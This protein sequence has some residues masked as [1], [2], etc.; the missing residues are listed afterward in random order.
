M[1]KTEVGARMSE[2][3]ADIRDLSLRYGTFVALDRLSMVLPA[4][5]ITALIGESGSGK[6]SLARA[7]TG[8]L[9]GDASISGEIAWPKLA[10]PPRP[11][12]D[13]GYV[14]QEPAASFDPVMSIG[15]QL[16]E[17]LHVTRCLRHKEALIQ[18]QILLE[19]VRIP[20]L[21]EALKKYPHQFSGGQLQRIA[22]AFALAGQ[23]RLL[24]ADEPTSALDT[25]VQKDIVTLLRRLV[26][27]QHLSL[28][29]ITHD[30]ALA[31]QIA[32][33]IAVL[34]RGKLVDMANTD[35]LL[36]QPQSAYTRELLAAVPRLETGH[37]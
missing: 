11:G 3:L 35:N 15:A 12:R 4:Q 32:D 19:N 1:A 21:E 17:I 2:I 31:S 28:L 27:E 16:I 18:A 13:F 36:R 37:G 29:F 24:I 7:L 30:I 9:S 23:P 14:F 6:T 20:Q 33:R 26:D 10:H 25:L 22:I 5:G 8:L 34:H